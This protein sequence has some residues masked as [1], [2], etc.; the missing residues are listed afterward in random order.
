MTC[1]QCHQTVQPDVA[2]CGNC[3]YNL[4]STVHAADGQP[5]VTHPATHPT[6]AEGKPVVVG[7]VFET[8]P[9][10]N[11]PVSAARAEP[12]DEAHNNGKAIAAFI[13]GVLGLVGWLIPLVGVI[14][15]ILALVFGTIALKSPRRVFAIIGI[16]LAVPVIGVSIFFWVRTAQH[17][18]K[19]NANP[20]HGLTI[21]STS[22]S[23]Q[24][25]TTPCYTTK[26][27]ANMSISRSSGSCTFQAENSATGELYVVK[28]LQ[29]AGLS[30]ANLQQAGQNDANNVVNLNPGDSITNQY[31]GTFAADPSYTFVLTDTANGGTD[32]TLAYVYVTTEQGNIAVIGHQSTNVKNISLSVLENNWQWQ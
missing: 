13:F 21:P 8:A 3:G 7:A 23:L 32:A 22:S 17:V 26:V 31:S 4:S 19:D 24:T 6:S 25:V 30:T 20:V 29:V 1:P 27:P 14:L 10:G 12:H 18:L 28:I 2:F 5:A 11:G 15:G 9:P 16:V